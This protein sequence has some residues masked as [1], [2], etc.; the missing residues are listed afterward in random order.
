MRLWS[1]HPKYLDPQGLV[2]LWRE[3]LLAQK[4]LQGETRGYTAHPQLE[5]FRARR[6]AAAAVAAYL[7]AVHVEAATRGYSFDAGKIGA[8][9]SR[10]LIAV[11]EGQL[12][13]EW[14]H[15]MRKLSARNPGLH[16]QW[17]RVRAPEAHPLF[18]IGPGEIETWE[19]PLK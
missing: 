1:L 11:T 7:A 3:A 6:S 9:R 2:A 8:S 15:L 12:A 10:K 4:V 19:R 5:R 14:E 17:R 18:E 13:Y 16:R